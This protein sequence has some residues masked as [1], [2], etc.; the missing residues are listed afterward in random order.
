M[1]KVK[2]MILKNAGSYLAGQTADVPEDQAKFMCEVRKVHD[3]TKL[4]EFRTAMPIAEW[5]AIQAAPVDKGGLTQD[6]LA[7]LGMKNVV[8]TPEAELNKPFFGVKKDPA[9]LESAKQEAEEP[10]KYSESKKSKK[11]AS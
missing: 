3:G 5:E 1:N 11:A 7:D 8:Q 10:S 9:E 2:L 6:E 4:V